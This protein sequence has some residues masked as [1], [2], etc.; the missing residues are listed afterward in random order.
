MQSK[1]ERGGGG[2]CKVLFAPSFHFKGRSS[3]VAPPTPRDVRREQTPVKRSAEKGGAQCRVGLLTDGRG[4][5]QHQNLSPGP[6]TPVYACDRSLTSLGLRGHIC[7]HMG[8]T[9]TKAAGKPHGCCSPGLLS[10]R[11]AQL[12]LPLSGILGIRQSSYK[13]VPLGEQGRWFKSREQES[14]NVACPRS[15]APRKHRQGP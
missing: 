6:A 15:P 2:G 10:D 9:T 1:G 12:P 8:L 4:M 14:R 7:N 13:Q 3:P 11:E 5:E